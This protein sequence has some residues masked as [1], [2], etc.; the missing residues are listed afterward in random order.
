MVGVAF[1]A[2]GIASPR[3]ARYTQELVRALAGDQFQLTAPPPTQADAVAQFLKNIGQT[4]IL[5][6]VLLAMGSV[7]TEKERGIVALILSKPASRA[8]CLAASCSR[9]RRRSASDPRRH[10]ASLI[11]LL[12][13]ASSAAA[14]EA[15]RLLALAV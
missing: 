6:A 1:L 7:A 12:F 15:A 13:A 4:G 14:G 11:V 3:L 9:S 10:R 8:G 5:A 2:F